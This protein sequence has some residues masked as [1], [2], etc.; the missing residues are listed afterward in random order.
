MSTPKSGS[1]IEEQEAVEAVEATEATPAE[2]PVSESA[3]AAPA[4]QAPVLETPAESAPT[5]DSATPEYQDPVAALLAGGDDDDDDDYMSVDDD[6]EVV[7]PKG[8]P[9]GAMALVGFA[10]FIIGSALFIGSSEELNARFRCQVLNDRGAC[11]TKEDKI[12]AIEQ[13]AKKEE[14][15]LM[16]HHYGA[17]DLSFSP[18]SD[19]SFTL[20][21]KRYEEARDDFVKRIR[22]GA[23]DKRSFKEKKVG[24]YSTGKSVEGVI[25]GRIKFSTNPPSEI[26]FQPEQGKALVLP[27]SLADL[28]LLEREQVDGNGKRL[29]AEDVIKLEKERDIAPA[30]ARKDS[31]YK[32]KTQALSTWVYEIHISAKGFKPRSIVF[33]EA[34]LPPDIDRK[35]LETEQKITFRSFSRRPDGKFVIE[36]ATFDLLPEPR[37]LWTRYIQAL[38]EIHC[39]QKTKEYKARDEQ[40]QKDAESL[41]WEQ[42]AFTQELLD[43]AHQN[44]EDPEWLK[45]KEEQ[46]K[47]YKC[48]ELVAR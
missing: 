44:D 31:R 6:D 40:G 43:I 18:E 47:G 12:W 26:T 39:L 5:P 37:T 14:M 48:P 24:V 30:E 17:F 25:K 13:Q 27:L 34:P 9:W 7:G 33:F 35:K 19:A 46:F 4:E 22:E 23:E 11:V 36:N 38:K 28:P 21:Q 10:T 41:L 2:T 45:Y 29:T 16:T 20:V 3:E 1:N 42:K 32:V 8:L 15:E